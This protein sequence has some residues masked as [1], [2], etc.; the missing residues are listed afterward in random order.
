MSLNP[1]TKLVKKKLAQD[2]QDDIFRKMPTDK[3]IKL[4]S[5]FFRLAKSLNSAAFDYGAGRVIE[6]NRKNSW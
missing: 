5:G 4:V 2:I 6:K 1:K 3:K